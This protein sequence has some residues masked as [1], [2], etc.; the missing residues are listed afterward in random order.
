MKEIEYI[1]PAMQ[2]DTLDFMSGHKWNIL[3]RVDISR[4]KLLSIQPLMDFK[5]LRFLNA[6]NN[7]IVEINF[8]LPNIEEIDLSANSLRSFPIFLIQHNKLKKLVL[9][10]NSIRNLTYMSCTN[11]MSLEELDISHNWY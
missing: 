8:E 5:N 4:N 3:Q 2:L 11:F 1:V 7:R 6:R 10:N 9:S